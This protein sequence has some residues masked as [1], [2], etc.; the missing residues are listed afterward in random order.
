MS[1]PDLIEFLKASKAA[2]VSPDAV[3]VVK[4][5]LCPDLAEDGEKGSSVFDDEDSSLTRCV[6][7]SLVARLRAEPR[8]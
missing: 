4:E 5:N 6:R 2:L 3:L 8:R 7:R 1:T